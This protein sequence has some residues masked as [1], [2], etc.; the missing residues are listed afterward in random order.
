MKKLLLTAAALL[1]VCSVSF[2]QY[3]DEI[4][5]TKK[6]EA[7]FNKRNKISV[8]TTVDSTVGKKAFSIIKHFNKDGYLTQQRN[9]SSFETVYYYKYNKKNMLVEV[10]DSNYDPVF[11]K[12]FSN[13]Y[14]YKYYDNGL[15]KERTLNDV[16]VTFDYD[17]KLNKLTRN[18]E[19]DFDGGGLFE[20]Y[21][22]TDNRLLK[23]VRNSGG[24]E[25]TAMY[26][27]AAGNMVKEWHVTRF[28]EGYDSV[29]TVYQYD[30]KGNLTIEET[31]GTSVWPKYNENMEPTGETDI[32][33]QVFKTEYAY[34][35][36]GRPVSRINTK[37]GAVEMQ[38]VFTRSEAD[39]AV[40]ETLTVSTAKGTSREEVTKYDAKGLK[41]QT[42]R[43]ETISDKPVT[44]LIEYQYSFY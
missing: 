33:E 14:S 8:I 9:L 29:H 19:S 43:K 7:E 40:T 42:T 13:K 21:Y 20:Y 36:K 25:E 10:V 2:A 5:P 34:D 1:A 4:F 26:E 38:E 6:K 12:W 22:D 35:E 15:L 27:Y 30:A 3:E 16:T 41:T 28:N 44:R 32:T 18:T 37:N 31:H 11:K 39:G 17:K 23:F 24:E